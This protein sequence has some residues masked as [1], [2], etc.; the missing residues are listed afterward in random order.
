M[1]RQSFT[2]AGVHRHYVAGCGECQARHRAYQSVYRQ[3]NPGLSEKKK[4]YKRKR[5]AD[6]SLL[7]DAIQRAIGC[8]DCG[9]WSDDTVVFDFDHVRGEKH[10]GVSQMKVFNIDRLMD[11]IEKCEVVCA[12]CHRLRTKARAN[13]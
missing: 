9:L 12:N 3:R 6:R 11:E 2:H 4:A 7:V 5:H 8:V 13:V 1:G 10:A